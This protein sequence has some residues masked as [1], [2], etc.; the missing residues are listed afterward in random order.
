VRV[1]LAVLTI[2]G[3]LATAGSAAASPVFP[4]AIKSH[5]ALSYSPSCAICHE[6]GRGGTGTVTTPFGRAMMARG[7]KA[8]D[9]AA[10]T[11]ALDQMAAEKVD[12][13]GN[14]VSDIDQLKMGKDPN[15]GSGVAMGAPPVEYGCGGATV[16]R[17]NNGDGMLIALIV[18]GLVLA[19]RRRARLLLPT[20]VVASLASCNP[21]EVSY[22]APEVC[23]SGRLWTAGGEGDERMNPGMACIQCHSRG[24]GPRFTVAGTLFVASDEKDLCAGSDA[25]RVY[26]QGADGR[27]L[28]LVPNDV[29]NFHSNRA[30]AFPYTAWVQT[31][32]GK[33]RKMNAQQSSGDCNSCH[34]QHGENGAPGRVVVP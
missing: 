18:G 12:S 20:L 17:A 9:T 27:T 30:V 11:S 34:T 8:G 13:D 28:E 33:V 22:V 21:Y 1:S 7:L 4:D 19:R 24:E 23:Q 16:A 3:V 5:L 32:D 2:F 10:L 26:V 15:G 6:G 29:G 14:G 31:A 25:A